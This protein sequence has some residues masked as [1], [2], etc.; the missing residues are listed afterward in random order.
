M[1]T[2]AQVAL[3]VTDEDME[4]PRI[5]PFAEGRAAVF[6]ARA[7]EKR[8]ANGDAVGLLALDV[9]RGVLV[10]ADGLG[11]QPGGNSASKITLHCLRTAVEHASEHGTPIRGA[12]LDALE[13]ANR[14]VMDLGI[15]AATTFAALEVAGTTLRPYHVGDS[16]ILVVGQRRKVK[17][18]TVSHSPVGYAVEAGLLDEHEAMHHD[19]RHV[20]SNMVGAADMRIEVG[21]PIRLAPRDTALV[22]TDGLFDN[23]NPAEV[24]EIVRAGPLDRAANDLAMRSAERMRTSTAKHPSKPDD[25]TFVLYRRDVHSSKAR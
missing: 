23:L 4:A 13:S 11:G 22:A 16:G 21:S 20:V 1:T 3:V 10:V 24:V 2:T 15:G 7:P 12:I 5:M 9:E 17:L 25:L 18:Q 14:Q 19:E 8:S 6:S